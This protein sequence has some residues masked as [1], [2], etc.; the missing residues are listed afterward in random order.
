ML[1]VKTLNFVSLLLIAAKVKYFPL[2]LDDA[3]LSASQIGFLLGVGGVAQLIATP[4]WGALA[5]WT[6]RPSVILGVSLTMWAVVLQSFQ[7]QWLL[8]YPLLCIC[9]Y[10]ATCAFEGAV[11]LIDVV[12]LSALKKSGGGES[13]GNQRWLA[14]LGFGSGCLASGYVVEIFGYMALFVWSIGFALLTIIAALS[15]DHGSQNHHHPGVDGR[16]GSKTSFKN[17]RNEDAENENDSPDQLQPFRELE[18]VTAAATSND[19]GT[20]SMST[21][22]SSGLRRISGEVKEEDK[23]RGGLLKGLHL[24]RGNVAFRNFLG[25]AVMFGSLVCLVEQI[26]I[27]H[28]QQAY[29]VSKTFVGFLTLFGT[30]S[31]IPVFC[32]SDL[33]LKSVGVETAMLISHLSIALRL[34]MLAGISL[35]FKGT[36]TMETRSSEMLFGFGILLTQSLHGLSLVPY[37]SA[38]VERIFSIA[39]NDLKG[40]Y[41]GLFSMSFFPLA[42]SIGSVVW[43][44]IYERYGGAAT[45]VA[46]T[47]FAALSSLYV[48]SVLSLNST[49][50]TPSS[51]SDTMT[52]MNA[53]VNIGS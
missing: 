41:L 4:I 35:Y 40:A 21:T 31:E 38:G 33:L 53:A 19:V 48:R 29:Q 44:V 30:V 25:S 45:Y 46:G 3:G 24:A 2:F 7:L 6:K 18:D 47:C 43:S 1:R 39:P 22:D 11:S 23:N 42:F 17:H 32:Y 13:Y 8:R 15:L 50:K 36:E 28:I 10:A 51:T 34:L 27:L 9:A 20:A 5:D 26:M 52:T 14:S 12:T 37:W 49:T 16:K